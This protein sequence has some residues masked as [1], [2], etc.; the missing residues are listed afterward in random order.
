VGDGSNITD[1]KG[2]NIRDGTIDTS[3]IKDGTLT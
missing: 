2:D 3:E 1:I